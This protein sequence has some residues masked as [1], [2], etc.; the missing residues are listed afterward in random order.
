MDANKID[1]DV[2]FRAKLAEW[3]ELRAVI[4]RLKE[5]RGSLVGN[6]DGNGLREPFWSI[7]YRL[8]DVIA[9]AERQHSNYAER[10]Q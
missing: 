10:N 1:I 8:D 5:E 2:T 4:V 3:K 7:V 6:D 9:N